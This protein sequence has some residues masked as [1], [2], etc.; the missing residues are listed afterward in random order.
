MLRSSP[1]ASNPPRVDFSSL[2]FLFVIIVSLSE[3]KIRFAERTQVGCLCERFPSIKRFDA[4]K[5]NSSAPDP[6]RRARGS[7][8]SLFELAGG[9]RKPAVNVRIFYLWVDAGVQLSRT[10]ILR[11]VE[12][13]CAVVRV[14][15]AI[16]LLLH[17]YISARKR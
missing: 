17:L 13:V 15:V 11:Y 14:V 16:S 6:L 4:P 10:L 1:V 12:F 7:R 8:L 9:G 5:P 2:I 3:C